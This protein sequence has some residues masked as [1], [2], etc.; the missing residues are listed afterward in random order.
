MG[1]REGVVMLVSTDT[2][3]RSRDHED[4]PDMLPI[5]LMLDLSRKPKEVDGGVT[6]RY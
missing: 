1:D 4:E 2:G 6:G 5:W 3:D